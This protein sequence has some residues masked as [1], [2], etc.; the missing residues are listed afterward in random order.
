V[1]ENDNNLLG[2]PAQPIEA[3]RDQLSAYTMALQ[4]RYDRQRSQGH[5]RN[6]LVGCFNRHS[7]EK[8]VPGDPP[9]NLGDKRSEHGSLIAQTIDQIGFVP[10]SK[11]LFIDQTDGG[12]IFRFFTSDEHKSGIPQ[13]WCRVRRQKPGSQQVQLFPV[14]CFSHFG[15]WLVSQP[16]PSDRT[17]PTL[18]TNWRVWRSIAVRWFWISVASAVSTSR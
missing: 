6:R 9:L 12:A 2:S 11:R 14:P 4:F 10:P 16:P 18:S 8:D 13:T 5:R 17:S 7:A 1:A 3:V 15:N